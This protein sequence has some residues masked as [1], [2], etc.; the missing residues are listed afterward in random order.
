[1]GQERD[2]YPHHAPFVSQ[3]TFLIPSRNLVQGP[4]RDDVPGEATNTFQEL[5]KRII[6][7]SVDEYRLFFLPS[8]ILGNGS[9][10][11]TTLPWSADC[12]FH[13]HLHCTAAL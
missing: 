5:K 6:A 2:N 3:I 10:L 12:Y 8:H 9:M 11:G 13:F 4:S 7:V 1:M